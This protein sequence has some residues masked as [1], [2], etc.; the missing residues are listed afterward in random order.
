MLNK[1]VICKANSVGKTEYWNGSSSTNNA[2]GSMIVGAKLFDSETAAMAAFCGMQ[3]FTGKTTKAFADAVAAACRLQGVIEVTI[4]RIV[5]EQ[6]KK[7][8]VSSRNFPLT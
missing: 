5:T 7:F 2:W 3:K 1:Y 6:V 8:T 4:M